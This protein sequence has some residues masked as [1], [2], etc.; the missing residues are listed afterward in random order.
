MTSGLPGTPPGYR[1]RAGKR[2]RGAA[3]ARRSM[4]AGIALG[5]VIG[6]VFGLFVFDNMAIG[7][8]T[9]IGIGLAIG[10]ALGFG[11]AGDN[12]AREKDE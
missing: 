7:I 12:N 10:I 11:D 8:A 6:V 3:V 9:G 5:L 2:R 4:S 1:N